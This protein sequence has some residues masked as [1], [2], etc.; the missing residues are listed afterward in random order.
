MSV[1][2]LIF[3]HLI[4]FGA[5]V[6]TGK[7][8]DAGELATYREAHESIWSKIRRQAGTAAIG[9]AALG[10]LLLL[11]RLAFARPRKVAVE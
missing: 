7:A 1:R 10:G 6:L 3:S 5:G 4:L 11:A 9:A 8:I 2:N